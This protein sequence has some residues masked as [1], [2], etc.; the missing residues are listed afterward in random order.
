MKKEVFKNIRFTKE[1]W[2]IIKDR[3]NKTKC[4]NTSEYIRTAAL[5]KEINVY[6][7][8]VLNKLD[9]DLRKIGTNIN[10]LV[11]L[12]NELRSVNSTEVYRIKEEVDNIR[13]AWD[14]EFKPISSFRKRK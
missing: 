6:D 8:E 10:Q 7:L 1:E 13:L 2:E 12:C 9:Y 4:K 14:K 3:A 11:H 5:N